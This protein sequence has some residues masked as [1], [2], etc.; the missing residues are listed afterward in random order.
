MEDNKGVWT[1]DAVL[2]GFEWS[3]VLLYSPFCVSSPGPRVFGD[4]RL[5]EK[6]NDDDDAEGARLDGVLDCAFEEGWGD[7]GAEDVRIEGSAAC[8]ALGVIITELDSGIRVVSSAD[9]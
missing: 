4:E 3:V 5:E 9:S 6:D 2:I 7:I 8:E 1:S